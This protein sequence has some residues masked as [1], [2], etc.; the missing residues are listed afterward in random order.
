MKRF[1]LRHREPVAS[2]GRQEHPATADTFPRA[3]A[4]VVK[5]NAP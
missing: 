3:C 5:E 4:R 1:V 2:A